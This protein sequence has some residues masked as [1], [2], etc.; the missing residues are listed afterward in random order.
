LRNLN[1]RQHATPTPHNDSNGEDEKSKIIHQ[2][3][4]GASPM[5]PH[6]LSLRLNGF[7][8]R[9][10]VLGQS[11]TFLLFPLIVIPVKTQAIAFPIPGL[12]D[13]KLL[14]MSQSS[15]AK[16]AFPK[17][18]ADVSLK[19]FNQKLTALPKNHADVSLKTFKLLL[20]HNRV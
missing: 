6:F 4:E 15:F 13:S 3:P 19:T 18:H 14:R 1:K 17:N 2:A 11:P 10:P 7:S 16:R 20:W 12:A 8:F 9:M 5:V